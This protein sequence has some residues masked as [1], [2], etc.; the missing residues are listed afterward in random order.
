MDSLKRIIEDYNRVARTINST[1][2]ALSALIK[3]SLIVAS[4]DTRVEKEILEYV[5]E[6]LGSRYQSLLTELVSQVETLTSQ[7][8][9]HCI[10]MALLKFSLGLESRSEVEDSDLIMYETG[11]EVSQQVDGLAAMG[12]VGDVVESIKTDCG[13]HKR[14]VAELSEFLRTHLEEKIHLDINLV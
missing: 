11:L 13:G 7:E 6:S 8:W 9:N 10:E 5:R 4:S 14:S 3:K 1:I 12:H 2:L